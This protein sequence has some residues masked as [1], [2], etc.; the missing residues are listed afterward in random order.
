MQPTLVGT[1]I[2]QNFSGVQELAQKLGYPVPQNPQE[3]YNFFVALLTEMS[4]ACADNIT[5]IKS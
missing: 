1:I 3:G 2:Q 4:V 5:A